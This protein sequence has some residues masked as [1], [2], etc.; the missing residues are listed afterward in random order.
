MILASHGDTTYMMVN[1]E[2]GLLH[3]GLFTSRNSIWPSRIRTT[4]FG[5]RDPFSGPLPS[6]IFWLYFETFLSLFS[7]SPSPSS[8]WCLYLLAL[9]R[10]ERFRSVGFGGANRFSS[11]PSLPLYRSASPR[12]RLLDEFI[13]RLIDLRDFVGGSSR[14]SSP[15]ASFLLRFLDITGSDP[16]SSLCVDPLEGTNGSRGRYG[17]GRDKYVG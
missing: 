15:L 17:D 2:S 12:V 1:G 7:F 3:S 6:A 8:P 5:P 14:S 4:P 13:G 11:S 16:S 9:V 10:L